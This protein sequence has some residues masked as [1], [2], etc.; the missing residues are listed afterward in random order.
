M[1]VFFAYVNVYH[2]IDGLCAEVVMV[3]AVAGAGVID[4]THIVAIG[5]QGRGV[6]P[7][8]G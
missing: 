6:V 1:D 7:P 2:F 5:N 4:L 3:G 8:R